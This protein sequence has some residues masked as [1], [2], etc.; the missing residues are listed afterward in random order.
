MIFCLC[1]PYIIPRTVAMVPDPSQNSKSTRKALSMLI[2]QVIELLSSIYPVGRNFMA[3]KHS[4]WFLI[5][6]CS[7]DIY[8]V[9]LSVRTN[10]MKIQSD[11]KKS[12][13]EN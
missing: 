8:S 3:Q 4:P 6:I 2:L 12:G 13:K 10:G 9:F 1:L 5:K 7:S 11:V